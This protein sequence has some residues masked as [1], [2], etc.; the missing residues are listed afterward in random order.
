MLKSFFNENSHNAETTIGLQSAFSDWKLFSE[1]KFSE[2]KR[3]RKNPKVDPHLLL[4]N[5]PKYESFSVE[6]K[7][8]ISFLV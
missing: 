2:T 4:K 8:T 7:P 5:S 6:N 3:C 1:M